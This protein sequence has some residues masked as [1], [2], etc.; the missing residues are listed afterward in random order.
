MRDTK[1]I[2]VD[3]KSS[4]PVETLH[5]LDLVRFTR[6]HIEGPTAAGHQ[7]IIVFITAAGRRWF[8][9]EVARDKTV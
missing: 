6:Q 2:E 7:Q 1:C 9:K 5:D 8:W 3:G 4:R